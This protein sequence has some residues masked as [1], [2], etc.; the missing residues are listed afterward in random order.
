MH[1][2]AI[3]MIVDA[4]IA[5]NVAIKRFFKVISSIRTSRPRY[6]STWYPMT[7]LDYYRSGPE[8]ENINL[9]DLPKKIITLFALVTG[10]RM[11]TFLLIP[12]RTRYN[13][14]WYT[15]TV[16]D[17]YR[18]WPENENMNLEDLSKKIITLFAL[19]TGHR[20]QT[21]SLINTNIRST[22]TVIEIKIPD[23]IKTSTRNSNQPL[24]TL[25][26][27]ENKICVTSAFNCYLLR[28]EKLQGS[29]KKLFISHK[30]LFKRITSQSLSLWVKQEIAACGIDTL[31]FSSHSTPY[32]STSAAKRL[33][34]D[35]HIIRK[36]RSLNKNSK[37]FAKFYDRKIA[38]NNQA[39]A[40]AILN[41]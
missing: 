37:T 12:S 29:E 28:A 20:M 2:F 8:N 35:L 10:R 11:Q 21:F 15:M 7:V 4:D 30:K 41:G 22:D 3:S 19:V 27:S 33:G 31:V 36:T 39:F 18:S 17:Y 13:S 5:N 38:T 23:C 26:F 14:T 25:P 34:V 16:L 1:K 32:A 6:N 24:L 40:N 9:E